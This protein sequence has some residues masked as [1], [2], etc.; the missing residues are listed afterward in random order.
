[1]DPNRLNELLQPLNIEDDRLAAIAKA[2]SAY[3]DRCVRVRAGRE[4]SLPFETDIVPWYGQGRWMKDP[5]SRPSTFPNFAAG[6]YYIQDA[7]SLLALG[8]LDI[9]PGDVVC[10]LCAAPGG[11]ASGILERLGPGGFLIANEPIRSRA[12]ILRWS[13]ERTGNPRFGL[14]QSDPSELCREYAQTFDKILVDAPCSGQTLMAKGKRTENAMDDS[15]VEHSAARQRRILEAAVRMLKPGGRLVYS[16]C[17]FATLENESQ[18]DWLEE[19]YPGAWQS[20]E[21]PTVE[22]GDWSSWTSPLRENCYRL[23]PD[24]DR[25]AGAFAAALQWLGHEVANDDE[26]HRDGARQGPRRR[27][28]K[29][30]AYAVLE[31]F[32]AISEMAL[33]SDPTSVWGLASDVVD[34]LDAPRLSFPMLANLA[35]KAWQPGHAMAILSGRT[36]QPNRAVELDERQ[37]EAFMRGEAL[38]PLHRELGWLVAHWQGRP[39]GWL[40]QIAGRCNNFLPKIARN[41]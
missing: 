27:P 28:S 2:C 5:S 36:F 9:Q 6:D 26:I 39:L 13:L 41:S 3:S 24:R 22:T 23:W 33:A 16:T 40:K 30:D 10:D 14:S 12:E 25:C 19:R 20:I 31:G 7:G 35:G 11:K 18:I 1:M 8:L 38:G 34:W 4:G 29:V 32:G 21:P 17:T 15:Q 37:V